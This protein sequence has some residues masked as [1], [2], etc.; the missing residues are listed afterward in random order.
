MSLYQ[1]VRPT[2]FDD[3]AGNDETVESLQALTSRENPPHAYLLTGPSGCGKT[4]LG[5]IIA[6][7]LGVE[8]DDYRE[9]DSA[10]FRGIDTIR[11][12]RHGASFVGLRGSRRAWL[13]DEVHRLPGLSQDALLKGL[14]DPPP[15]AYF[16]L[17]TTAPESLL[18]TVR[19]RCSIHRVEPLSERHMVALL[20]KV[21]TGEGER[22]PRPLLRAIHE[23]TD[24]KP[25]AAINLLEKVLAADPDARDAV[26]AAHEAAKE[27]ADGLARALMRRSGW[28]AVASILAEV[29][30]DDVESVR[31]SIIGYC[32][33]V[34]LRG[35]DDNAMGIL[36][37]F[38]EP[39][40]NSGRSGLIH[41][42]Y[43]VCRS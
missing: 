10:D 1:K 24:G 6:S 15:H 40:F 38:I 30:E 12:I 4:T 34:L 36:D 31:R 14:E 2:S 7:S 19:G 17:C 42:C 26:V 20:H 3:V 35:E 18:E 39:F 32:S 37:E 33:A 13:L 16:I 25:R 5:R 21:A 43:T 29:S 28:K 23:K 27:K 9:V 22:L 11:D 41:A 8:A